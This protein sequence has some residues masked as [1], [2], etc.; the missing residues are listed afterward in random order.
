M[1]DIHQQVRSRMAALIQGS[2]RREEVA[3]WALEL[4]K[5]ESADYSSD[6]TLWTALDRL[7]G[8]DL[9]EGPGVYLHGEEDF[10]AWIA[11]LDA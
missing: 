3:D 8:A 9:Q 4:I 1:Q 6:S 10:R 2:V 7:A 5:D 11:D